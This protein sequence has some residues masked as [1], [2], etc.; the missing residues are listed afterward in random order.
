MW[1]CAG[2]GRFPRAIRPKKEC[3]KS[4]D[5]YFAVTPNLNDK[6]PSVK[7]VWFPKVLWPSQ[8]FECHLLF[9]H[10]RLAMIDELYVHALCSHAN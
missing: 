3:R 4:Y 6:G 5:T 7:C 9:D 8:V 10:Y 2:E 1:P